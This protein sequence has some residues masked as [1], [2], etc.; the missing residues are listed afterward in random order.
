[1]YIYLKNKTEK[2]EV[3]SWRKTNRSRKRQNNER[4]T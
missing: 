3:V 2:G 4:K 1:M